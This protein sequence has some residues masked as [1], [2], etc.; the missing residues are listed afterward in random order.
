LVAHLSAVVLCR[1]AVSLWLLGPLVAFYSTND[2]NWGLWLAPTNGA[3]PMLIM[4]TGRQAPGTPLGV[5]FTN[6]S[7]PSWSVAVQPVA[8]TGGEV[9]VTNLLGNPSQAAFYRVVRTD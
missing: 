5:V 2:N 4:H 1:L 3:M 8:G 6:L 7:V 9:T